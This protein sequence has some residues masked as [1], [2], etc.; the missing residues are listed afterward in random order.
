M[1]EHATNLTYLDLSTYSYNASPAQ[2]DS[3][4]ASLPPSLTYL[5]I[6]GHHFSRSLNH[7][8]SL[9]VLL[10]DFPSQSQSDHIKVSLNL[11]TLTHLD[12]NGSELVPQQFSEKLPYLERISIGL[13][14]LRHLTPFSALT[15]VEI[16]NAKQ[17]I[18]GKSFFF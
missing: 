11:P 9:L 15:F 7:L 4:F 1:F 17:K 13:L 3:L 8:N 5:N 16:K 6:R 12:L 14:E 2:S 10:C 18:H